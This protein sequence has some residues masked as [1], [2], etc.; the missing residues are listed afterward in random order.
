MRYLPVNRREEG[1]RGKVSDS[2][3]RGKA[4]SALPL[5]AYPVPY[6]VLAPNCSNRSKADLKGLTRNSKVPTDFTCLGVLS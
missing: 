1:H 4:L 2:G 6:T 3:S 5:L